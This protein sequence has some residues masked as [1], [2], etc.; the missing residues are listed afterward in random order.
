MSTSAS[1]S[2]SRRRF[3]KTAAASAVV[4][5]TIIPATAI[6]KGGRPAPSERIHVAL[7]GF[8]TIAQATTQGFLA[9][10]RAQVIAVADP[11][12]LLSNYG[13]AGELMGGRDALKPYIEK[14]YAERADGAEATKDCATYEDYRELLEKE[15]VNALNISTPD[16]W[17]AKMCLDGAAKGLHMYGQKPL[18]L[19]VAQGRLMADAVA[20][21]G[22]TWQT[23]SQQRS[24]VYFRTACEF[25]RNGRL[26]KLTGIKLKLPG[27]HKDWSKL[28][29]KQ[30]ITKV[31]DGLN[32]DLWEGPAPHRDYRPALL[33]LQWRHL[34]DYSG[35]MVTDFAAH[36]IDIVQWALGMDDSGPVKFENIKGT[37]PAADELYNTA[38][39][40]HFE[41]VYADGTRMTVDD[42]RSST[43]EILFEGEDGKSILV[44]RDALTMTPSE[45]RREKI[46]DDEIK[47]Y[48]S[49][50]HVENF[51]DCIYS[52]QPTVA[53]IEAA[54]R[55]ITISHLANIGIR[56]GIAAFDWDPSKEQSSNPTVNSWLERPMRAPYAI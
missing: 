39:G 9:D 46:K 21:A 41:C 15:D 36:H 53:P 14:F 2:S 22:V 32:Y 12:K 26:G 27:G 30:E 35:G 29:S 31:P 17:H 52:G 8:G 7:L 18:A 11:A 3:L 48:E 28:G 19:T 56:N 44:T 40:F 16:H 13:Y 4:F 38:T 24:D 5:P 43:G 47:L 34:Y 49:R 25:V 45:L 42:D 55:T 23:G 6:G 50:G 37:L 10:K 33:P 54:H 51:I 20:K 1:A